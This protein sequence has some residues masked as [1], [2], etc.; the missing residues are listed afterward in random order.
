[1]YDPIAYTL[2]IDIANARAGKAAPADAQRIARVTDD[3]YAVECLAF[4][5]YRARGGSDLNRKQVRDII[6]M[7]EEA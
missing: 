1:M 7:V 3:A 5:A 4:V 6:R 2:A